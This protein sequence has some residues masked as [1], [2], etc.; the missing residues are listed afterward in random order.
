MCIFA[1]S[2]LFHCLYFLHYQFHTLLKDIIFSLL[3]CSQ[4]NTQPRAVPLQLLN[5]VNLDRVVVPSRVDLLVVLVDKRAALLQKLT[6]QFHALNWSSSSSAVVVLVL[7][8]LLVLLVLMMMRMLQLL[9]TMALAPERL[10]SCINAACTL[11]FVCIVN[12]NRLIIEVCSCT[13][14]PA[15][16]RG[17]TWLP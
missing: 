9:L 13:L 12:N 3:H 1:P 10:L 14:I 7:L 6:K 4:H 8:L 15:P 16:A 17:C 5:N 2:S 11:H